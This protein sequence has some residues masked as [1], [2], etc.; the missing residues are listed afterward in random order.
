MTI[1]Q[2]EISPRKIEEDTAPYIG[3]ASV[4]YEVG[5]VSKGFTRQVRIMLVNFIYSV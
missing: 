2:I 4:Q 3:K 5:I 1:I